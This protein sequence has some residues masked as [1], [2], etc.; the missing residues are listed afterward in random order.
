MAN[1]TN[2]EFDI[3]TCKIIDAR[4]MEDTGTEDEP[5]Y[6]QTIQLL[7]QDASTGATFVAPLSEKDIRQL[8]DL[9]F[10]LHSKEMIEIAQWLRDFES[11]VRLLVPKQSN[12]INKD[13]LLNTPSQGTMD[14]G[15]SFRAKSFKRFN[16][17]KEKIKKG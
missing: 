17:E 10:E 2:D 8:A 9:D 15:P 6:N 5:A 3:R 16:F 7:L 14:I 1:E 13:L 12:K 11:D 4:H